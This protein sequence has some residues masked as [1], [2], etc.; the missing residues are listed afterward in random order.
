MSR[1][2]TFIDWLTVRDYS[3]G[4]ADV[5]RK[6]FSR[7]ARGNVLVQRGRYINEKDQADLVRRGDAATE[8]L[9][10]SACS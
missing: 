9:R 4:K 2:T 1:L 5:Q 6:V 8:R 7:F 3:K 10:R